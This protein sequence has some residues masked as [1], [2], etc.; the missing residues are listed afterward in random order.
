MIPI[1]ELF[2]GVVTSALKTYF[3]CENRIEDMVTGEIICL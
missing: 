3:D 1:K 2:D